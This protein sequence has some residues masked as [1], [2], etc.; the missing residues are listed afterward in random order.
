[1]WQAVI[2][3]GVEVHLWRVE[4]QLRRPPFVRSLPRPALLRASTLPCQLSTV[5]TTQP[6]FAANSCCLVFDLLLHRAARPTGA[7]T[8]VSAE[9]A[10]VSSAIGGSILAEFVL[11]SLLRL[12]QPAAAR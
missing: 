7:I 2:A 3:V 12:V 4:V 11:L 9:L 10:G 6:E 8:V 5:A 1:M